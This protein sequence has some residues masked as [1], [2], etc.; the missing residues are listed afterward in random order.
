MLGWSL[1]RTKELEYLRQNRVCRQRVVNLH[2]W[3][4][5]W[6][7][8]DIIWDYIFEGRGFVDQVREQYAKARG[9][10]VYGQKGPR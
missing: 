7:D 10:D 9:T 4:S 5:G 3:F 2:R 8:L 1:V 6:K